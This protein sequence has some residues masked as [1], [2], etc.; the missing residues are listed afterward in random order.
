MMKSATLAVD[1]PMRA[2]VWQGD[3]DEVWPTYNSSA[4]GAT[5]VFPRRSLSTPGE[6]AKALDGLLADATDRST[7]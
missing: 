1:L 5:Y 2:L 6:A 7:Q 4:Y 3:R